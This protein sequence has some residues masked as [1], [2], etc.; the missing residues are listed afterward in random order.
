[1]DEG[2]GPFKT[3]VVILAVGGGR[4]GRGYVKQLGQFDGKLL[5]IRPLAPA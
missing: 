5:K 2:D 4:L 1:V 3:V